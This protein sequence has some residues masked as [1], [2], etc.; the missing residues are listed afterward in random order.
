M[1]ARFRERGELDFD[2]ARALAVSR[3]TD[4]Q[5]ATRLS[6]ALAARFR[7]I[8]IDEAQDSNPDDLEVVKWLRNAGI[9][10]KI[11]CD[12]HQSIYAFRGGVTDQ[13]LAFGNTF[14]D[15]NRLTMSGN[16]RSSGNICK[17]IVML[18]AADARAIVDEPLG[19]FKGC[20]SQMM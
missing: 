11:I 4:A 17:A 2:D 1:Y 6:A 14:A 9:P 19:E 15:Q 8:I 18:R 7:E 13:L 3:L 5:L 16:F 12:P 10:T 20:D